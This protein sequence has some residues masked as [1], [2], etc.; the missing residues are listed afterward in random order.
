MKW[1]CGCNDYQQFW[2]PDNGHIDILVLQWPA[3]LPPLWQH[4]FNN[5][6]TFLITIWL[7]STIFFNNYFTF[8]YFKNVSQFLIF[9]KHSWKLYHQF[10]TFSILEYDTD[11]TN[12][13]VLLFVF[14]SKHFLK[15]YQTFPRF[16][17]FQI[18]IF[19][20]YNII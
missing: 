13:L 15:L 9:I 4:Y 3:R 12:T 5:Y 14:K 8:L 16:S 2:Q 17:P 19:I 11:Q 20:F 10:S 18:F 6:F 7:Y 1:Y